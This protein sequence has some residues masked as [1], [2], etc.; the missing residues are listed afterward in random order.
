[1]ATC[2][3]AAGGIGSHHASGNLANISSDPVASRLQA[4]SNANPAWYVPRW[5]CLMHDSEMNCIVV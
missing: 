1:M 5:F 4:S 2:S 3:Q